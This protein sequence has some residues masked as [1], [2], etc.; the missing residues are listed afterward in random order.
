MP[1]NVLILKYYSFENYFLNPTVMAQLG[2]V[3]SEQE[4]Y[5]IF[6][7]KWKEYLHRISSGK[8]LTEVLGKNLETTEDVKAHMEE[9][10]IYMRGHNLYDIF[11]GRY[12]KQEVQILTQYIELAPREDFADILDSI[13]RFIYFESRKN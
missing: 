3:E 8:K 10:R 11:Y 7:A 6:L 13:E 9:I 1:K 4:F 12:K 2:I 5:E